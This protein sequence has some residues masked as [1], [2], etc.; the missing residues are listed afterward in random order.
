M[1][2]KAYNE[3]FWK[4]EGMNLECL[5]CIPHFIENWNVLSLNINKTKLALVESIM[6]LL[7]DSEKKY[8]IE[9]DIKSEVSGFLNTTGGVVLFDC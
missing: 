5:G 6:C 3:S 1:K 7:I 4:H 9:N 2:K 8:K